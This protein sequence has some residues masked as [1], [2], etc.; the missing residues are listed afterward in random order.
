M[1]AARIL[2]KKGQLIIAI[3]ERTPFKG[4]VDVLASHR[5]GA[6]L[7]TNVSNEAVGIV[8]ERDIIGVLAKDPNASKRTASE[9]MTPYVVTCSP[10]DAEDDI[11]RIMVAHNVRHLPAVSNGEVI[12]MIS[13]RD[14][15]G[16][17]AEESGMSVDAS[18]A[19]IGAQ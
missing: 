3:D 13:A 19:A 10:A 7:V 5:I 12:G 11:I 2:D 16:I 17:K 1:T 8:S 4:V 14:I 6:L 9:I 18:G 15:L